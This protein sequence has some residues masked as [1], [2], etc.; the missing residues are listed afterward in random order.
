MGATDIITSD[1][2][3]IKSFFL[4]P[5]ELRAS[6]KTC[7]MCLQAGIFTVLYLSLQ[8]MRPLDRS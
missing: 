7:K 3:I 8:I 4:F 2:G 1:A 5:E 6:G